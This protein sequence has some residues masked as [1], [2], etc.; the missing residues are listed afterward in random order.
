VFA[1]KENQLCQSSPYCGTP[2][3]NTVQEIFEDILGAKIREF[4]FV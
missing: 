2:F 4:V 1:Y 3:T